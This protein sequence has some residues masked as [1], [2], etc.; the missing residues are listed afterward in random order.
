M[1]GSL[2]EDKSFSPDLSADTLTQVDIRLDPYMN[3]HFGQFVV[4]V[5]PPPGI[6]EN[7]M[8]KWRRYSQT[9]ISWVQI[10]QIGLDA[11]TDHSEMVAWA[12]ALEDGAPLAEA[13]Q[14]RPRLD[15]DG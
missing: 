10:T 9:V 8:D 12:T 2:V 5:E 7:D 15:T 4:I 11:Y 13:L 3:G 14:Y 6:I 1:P